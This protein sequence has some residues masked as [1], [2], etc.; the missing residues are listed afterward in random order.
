MTKKP[1]IINSQKASSHPLSPGRFYRASVTFVVPAGRVDVY[2]PDLGVPYSSIVPVGTT[3]LNKLAAGDTVSCTFT[4]E[5]FNDIVVFGSAGIK[6]DVF[7]S[8]VLFEE[9]L[10]NFGVLLARV[11]ALETRYNSHTQHPPPA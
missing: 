8:K 2:L 10:T 11:T 9:L 1:N 3:E 7:A 5:F 6:N 4:D